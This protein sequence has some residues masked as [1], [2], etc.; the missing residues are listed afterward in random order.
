M[1]LAWKNIASNAPKKACRSDDE[2]VV[3]FAMFPQQ[4]EA[5]LKPKP[6]ATTGIRGPAPLRVSRTVLSA[7]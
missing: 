3:L 6:A 5:L 4:V 1:N 2:I 7:R